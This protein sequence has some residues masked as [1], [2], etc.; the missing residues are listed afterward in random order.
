MRY[1]RFAIHFICSRLSRL[2]PWILLAIISHFAFFVLN[3]FT[4]YCYGLIDWRAFLH[5]IDCMVHARYTYRVSIRRCYNSRAA[6]FQDNRLDL[7]HF[8]Q[9]MQPWKIHQP[10]LCNDSKSCWVAAV[11]TG[12]YTWTIYNSWCWHSLFKHSNY[13][14]GK[15]TLR[16]K[17]KGFEW[18][19]L[20]WNS[21]L[22]EFTSISNR[23]MA[24]ETTWEAFP[25]SEW[26]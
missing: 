22:L 10:R 7:R 19:T 6:G 2:S 24:Y 3:P 17:S 26:V 21:L 4:L 9:Q 1:A 23:V 16:L 15:S 8:S 12:H 5:Y 11:M 13:I 14:L 25:F 18:K 20:C